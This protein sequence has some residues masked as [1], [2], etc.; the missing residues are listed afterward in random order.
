MLESLYSCSMRGVS[1]DDP[2]GGAGNGVPR[3]LA[4]NQYSRKVRETRP[5]GTTTWLRGASLHGSGGNAR[6]GSAGPRPKIAMVERRKA[7]VPRHGTQ[8]RL[9]S[10]P[11]CRVMARPPDA[12][13]SGRLSALRPPLIGW[14]MFQDPG[15]HAPREREVLRAGLFDI[16]SRGCVQPSGSAMRTCPRGELARLGAGQWSLRSRRDA[17]ILAKQS[18]RR[19]V[20]E[21]QCIWLGARFCN[22]P[23]S[24]GLTLRSIA[25]LLRPGTPPAQRS[26]LS[27]FPA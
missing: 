16:V 23:R 1:G 14:T 11:T 27:R 22:G 26:P 5:P 9:A 6:N 25:T 19:K 20:Q 10:A 8:G 13:A 12:A 21:L 4:R 3:V 18:Q 24:V 15:A 7:R 2:E 17:R